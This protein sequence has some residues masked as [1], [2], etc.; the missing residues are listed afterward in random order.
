MWENTTITDAGSNLLAAWVT[1]TT[2]HLTRA[3]GGTGLSDNLYSM[4]ALTNEKQAMS[5]ISIERGTTAATVKL[6]ITNSGETAFTMTQI[7]IFAAI[8][9]GEEVLLA[10]YQDPAGVP[11]PAASTTQ[12]FIYNFFATIVISNTGTL[13]L[14]IDSS[15]AVTMETMISYFANKQNVIN[16]EG[17]AVFDGN[18]GFRQ[19]IEGEDY[20]TGAGAG[21]FYGTSSTAKGTTRKVVTIAD[22]DELYQGDLIVVKFT[23]ANTATAPTLKINSLDP[24]SIVSKG[25]SS[26]LSEDY[27]S[28]GSYVLFQYDGTNAVLLEIFGSAVQSSKV[29]VAGGVAGIESDGMI[30]YSYL[31]AGYVV[32]ASAPSNTKLLWI[33]NNQ[34]MR[35]YD[36]TSNSWKLVLPS[37]G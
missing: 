21:A 27:W 17:L 37:W 31:R 25:Q 33:D 36:D 2:L 13:T 26:L 23:N 3:A 8:D 10:I 20:D 6:Q 34:L 11:I 35:Y 29:G 30:S 22:C 19:A 14:N 18:G 32:Q 5:I 12:E 15:A 7:G 28:A 9:D 24:V 1:G 4:T 16:I